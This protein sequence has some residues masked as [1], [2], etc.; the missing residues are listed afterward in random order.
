MIALLPEHAERIYR[1][2]TL[3][4]GDQPPTIAAIGKYNHGKSRLLNELI[5]SKVFEVADK[6]QTIKLE[7]FVHQGVSWLDA[8][9]LDADVTGEDDLAAMRGAWLESDVRLFVHAAKEGELD[10]KELD[11]LEELLAD[12]ANTQRRTLLVLTRML[13][14]RR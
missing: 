9:G 1:L 2:G 12:D 8:P 13:K 4:D 14:N 11:L 6:R 3:I 5:G 10:A 7:S